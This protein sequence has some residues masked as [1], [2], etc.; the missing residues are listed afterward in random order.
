MQVVLY[1]NETKGSSEYAEK[2]RVEIIGSPKYVERIVE[3][4][5]EEVNS[6]SSWKES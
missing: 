2:L 5:R 1:F 6:W 4:V 3:V